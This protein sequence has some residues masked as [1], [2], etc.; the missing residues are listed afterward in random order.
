MRRDE[1]AAVEKL[2]RQQLRPRLDHLAET[3]LAERAKPTDNAAAP[4]KPADLLHAWVALGMA[5][6]DLSAEQF[7]ARA[8]NWPSGR[9]INPLRRELHSPLTDRLATHRPSRSSLPT[10]R[11]GDFRDWFVTGDAFGQRPVA[12]LEFLPPDATAEKSIQP[13]LPHLAEVAAAHS[14]LLSTK[15]ARALRSATFTIEQ[16]KIWYRLYGS[17]GEVRLIVDGFRND[18]EPNLRRPEIRPGRHDAALAGAG[19]EQ[20]DRPQCVH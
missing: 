12:F 11:A 3:L 20:V 6:P 15:L 14:G 17:S 1:R 16:P 9:G 19:R 18:P 2:P 13:G 4:S 5:K 7:H 10:F 8:R